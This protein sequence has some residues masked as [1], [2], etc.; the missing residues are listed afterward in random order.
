MLC[1]Q[2]W[3]Y[4]DNWPQL[5]LDFHSM[6]SKDKTQSAYL[7]VVPRLS[8]ERCFSLLASIV[9]R[10][11]TLKTTKI[12]S[13]IEIAAFHLSVM[14]RVSIRVTTDMAMAVYSTLVTIFLIQGLHDLPAKVDWFLNKE[15]WYV[16]DARRTSISLI[17]MSRKF[18]DD[19]NKSLD[20]LNKIYTTTPHRFR[21]PLH[22]ALL[23]T[24][25]Y[26]LA[27]VQLHTKD[28]DRYSL[29]LV[30]LCL[31]YI[32]GLTGSCLDFEGPWK[33]ETCILAQG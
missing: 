14:W 8:E 10:N 27:P 13:N 20:F 3:Q 24:P 17:T 19:D 1:L 2:G 7:S 31:V 33:S 32:P 29:L 16:R 15:N 6:F 18:I 28:W 11:D 21:L 12:Y 26:L 22:L 5:L 4:L 30:W 9:R 23:V 25:L